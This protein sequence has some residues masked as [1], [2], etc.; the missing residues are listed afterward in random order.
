MR[1][2][3]IIAIVV[4]LVVGGLVGGAF[5]AGLIDKFTGG[6]NG[7]VIVDPDNPDPDAQAKIDAMIRVEYTNVRFYQREYDKTSN[8][9]RWE[10][11]YTATNLTSK[12]INGWDCWR[13]VWYK[14]ELVYNQPAGFARYV[15]PG[16]T[17]SG[18]TTSL[19]IDISPDWGEWRADDFSFE[20]IITK[21]R[22]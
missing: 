4:V 22:L 8:D 18:T 1:K 14:D 6:G 16:E 10:Y 20:I 17:R 9:V 15:Q 5:A 2:R 21:V 19:T 3:W 11:T 7:E 12:L 13:K